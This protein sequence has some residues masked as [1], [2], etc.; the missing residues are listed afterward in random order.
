MSIIK[1]S[2]MDFSKV[3]FSDVRKMGKGKMV[4]VNLNGGKIILQT[5]KMSTPFGVSRWRDDNA[6]D[7]K[8]DSFRLGLSFYGEDSNTEI[9]HFKEQLEAF[10]E[11]VKNEI[12]K[13]SKEWLGKPNLSTELIEEAFYVSNVKVPKD[14]DGNLLDY[15]SRFEV[16]LDRQ[17]NGDDFTG[18]FVSNKKFNHEVLIYDENKNLVP[19]DENNYDTVIPKGSQCITIVELV[20]ISITAKVSCKWKLVQA[21]VFKNQKAITDY[22]IDDSDSESESGEQENELKED[23]E[24]EN[25]DNLVEVTESTPCAEDEEVNGLADELQETE[26]D[27]SQ[28]DKLLETP[29]EKTTAKKGTRKRNA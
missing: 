6:D 27:D 10:D 12:K 24:S 5:P 7:N 22:A 21:K 18:K 15:P 11:I 19:M 8:G 25:S 16:K 20:Y 4:Y 13:N 3:T 28:M 9:R 29:A 23:L 17:K 26:L 1:A 14:S 2:Q